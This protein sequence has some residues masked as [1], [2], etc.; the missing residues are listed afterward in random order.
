MSDYDKYVAEVEARRKLDQAARTQEFATGEKVARLPPSTSSSP[1]QQQAII[2]LGA[3]VERSLQRQMVE[4]FR[5]TSDRMASA[6]PP[7][8]PAPPA[9]KSWGDRAYNFVTGAEASE[10][11]EQIS[12]G[13]G[14]AYAVEQGKLYAPE[15]APGVNAMPRVAS[16]AKAREYDATDDRAKKYEIAAEYANATEALPTYE[17]FR[18]ANMP[19]WYET[20][21]GWGEFFGATIQRGAWVAAADAV[22]TLLPED[23]MRGD[24]AEAMFKSAF[25]VAR[26]SSQVSS[27]TGSIIGDMPF[28]F[29]A[30]GRLMDA[31]QS[32]ELQAEWSK[33][34]DH[35]F[36]DY[37][38]FEGEW[39]LPKADGI[40][41]INAA[42]PAD[43]MEEQARKAEKEG[44]VIRATA[45]REM[46][47]PFK[48]EMAGIALEFFLDPTH[49]MGGA[50][51]VTYVAGSDG[52]MYAIGRQ[53]SKAAAVAAEATGKSSAEMSRHFIDIAVGSPEQ[54]QKASSAL[55]EALDLVEE[56]AKQVSMRGTITQAMVTDP[57]AA[58]KA[59]TE[60]VSK[61]EVALDDLAKLAPGEVTAAKRYAAE[62]VLRDANAQLDLVA[63]QVKGGWAKRAVKQEAKELLQAKQKAEDL[64]GALN[65]VGPQV[66]KKGTF[67]VT[68]PGSGKVGYLLS[69]NLTSAAGARV[70]K[71][72]KRYSSDIVDHARNKQTA[73]ELLTRSDLIALELGEVSDQARYMK[74]F[75]F[76]IASELWADK[77][78]QP[79]LLKG[80]AAKAFAGTQFASTKV[81]ARVPADL[82]ENYTRSITKHIN[83]LNR[84]NAE[85]QGRIQRLADKAGEVVLERRGKAAAE[86]ANGQQALAKATTLAERDAAQA[87]IDR[88]KLWGSPDYS[89][90]HV[91]LEAGA[92]RERGSG[93]LEG[94][95]GTR[96]RGLMSAIDDVKAEIL[97]QYPTV[98][99]DELEQAAQA[100]M[101]H[102]VWDE[103]AEKQLANALGG[104]VGAYPKTGLLGADM[105]EYNK[106]VAIAKRFAPP[107]WFDD[108]LVVGRA[109][110]GQ[111]VLGESIARESLLKALNKLGVVFDG[112]QRYKAAGFTV[113]LVV[114]AMKEAGIT[115]SKAEVKRA[116]RAATMG[117]K[118]LKVD[119]LLK[120]LGLSNKAE[121]LAK[122]LQEITVNGKVDVVKLR[123]FK[124]AADL[125]WVDDRL[126][127]VEPRLVFPTGLG[128]DPRKL[129]DWE[130]ALWVGLQQKFQMKNLQKEELIMSAWASIRYAPDP[131]GGKERY[132]KLIEDYGQVIGK[133][134]D[135][136]P[137]D[138]IDVME[139]FR[140]LV[141]SYE[142]M[143]AKAGIRI[144]KDPL[145]RMVDWGVVDYVPHITPSTILSAK[146]GRAIDDE[147]IS[148]GIQGGEGLDNR[149]STGFDAAKRRRMLGTVEEINAMARRGDNAAISLTLN[150]E[151]MLARYMQSNRGI[152]AAELL[153]MLDAGG[154]MR[155]FGN[156][157]DAAAQGYVPLVSM[158]E[159]RRDIDFLNGSREDI[160]K[161]A[162]LEDL[163]AQRYARRASSQGGKS[164]PFA[165]W[166]F[167]APELK[168]QA[169]VDDAIV[170]ARIKALEDGKDFVARDFYK[171][172]YDDLIAKKMNPDDARKAAM[173]TTAGRINELVGDPD[174]YVQGSWLSPAAFDTPIEQMY[175]PATVV[176]SMQAIFGNGEP[177]PKIFKAYRWV[178]NFFKTRATII[179]MAFSARN[180]ASN[181]VSNIIDV[182]F[183]GALDP[184]TNWDAGKMATRILIA[185]AFGGG[186]WTEAVQNLQ[187]VQ[188]KGLGDKFN[189]S[190][191]K[192]AKLITDMG[193]TSAEELFDE[194]GHAVDIGD[195]IPRS[196]D[197]AIALYRNAGVIQ[198]RVGFEADM[199]V[200]YQG[201]LHGFATKSIRQKA[202]DAASMFEDAVLLVGPMSVGGVPVAL[203]KA[204]GQQVARM[205]EMQARLVNFTAN[206]KRGGSVEQAAM[207]VNKYLFDY[208]D[209][210]HLQKQYMRLIFPFWTW[211][212]KNIK[213]YADIA[214]ESPSKLAMMQRL[215]LDD[216]VRATNA[217]LTGEEQED[218]ITPEEMLGRQ[219]YAWSRVRIPT[220]KAG[221]WIE[222]LGLPIE[223]AADQIGIFGGLAKTVSTW[224]AQAW[225]DTGG[226]ERFGDRMLAQSSFMAKFGH[227][228]F[229]NDDPFRG[230]PAAEL[231]PKYLQGGMDMLTVE[232]D[233]AFLGPA[234]LAAQEFLH[235]QAGTFGFEHKGKYVLVN[236]STSA[237]K[238]NQ[239]MSQS[240]WSRF[241]SGSWAYSDM[242]LYTQSSLAD[243]SDR[244]GGEEEEWHWAWK[245]LDT[246]FGADRTNDVPEWKIRARDK[247]TGE[248]SDRALK[249]VGSV[250]RL[251]FGTL[252]TDKPR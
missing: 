6:P 251:E 76:D 2:D 125:N 155:R 108:D 86:L 23:T 243:P 182:G 49:G 248:E 40:D 229:L 236:P 62:R 36:V 97:K 21:P 161:Q 219:D 64:R 191:A 52:V 39:R 156:A 117:D 37:N 17:E 69:D 48:R 160:L 146:S 91:L 239:V 85:A 67:A 68:V 73:G 175:V 171:Q 183:G 233:L 60:T 179:M 56:Q 214:T 201:V 10:K 122:A 143:Y 24:V 57:Q 128:E 26:T 136:M 89:V 79:L 252:D 240:P 202:K 209:L 230:V 127:A 70:S 78:Y 205:T 238:L 210:T 16:M 50:R 249:M 193:Y 237:I 63:R 150:P 216:G 74:A 133:R 190:V 30:G 153:S 124:F 7:T 131:V 221:Q 188:G 247:E 213:L 185:D 208:D 99:A 102:G 83:Q 163:K 242:K 11:M 220:G 42:Y 104:L 75:T 59:A 46:N 111:K 176:A 162:N 132:D 217:A 138:L 139:E 167:A 168:K 33:K 94:S 206:V 32:G 3:R 38:P 53:T 71:V 145:Q 109:G 88:G 116:L 149:L 9:E 54:K 235:Q 241:Q 157:N 137:A 45:I 152:A 20:L 189:R 192:G 165:S 170:M 15:V 44:D 1:A 22:E 58:I 180:A 169:Q 148:K 126:R 101:R 147:L 110:L 227:A 8:V 173:N 90:D 119:D 12:K 204:W 218:L 144:T 245:V 174:L 13:R 34:M 234:G 200:A 212:T 164:S 100:I 130:A 172:T 203:P 61:A 107:G 222:G 211:T 82:W 66:G 184:R 194:L 41:V 250:K 95:M 224:E 31:V 228:L 19:A 47:T 223:S 112:S 120:E 51:G 151:H 5:A 178:E 197:E 93:L 118:K 114:D 141:L 106:A 84:I 231:S 28:H 135:D 177:L 187:R 72:V 43:L 121:R 92:A 207:H 18:A 225:Q 55:T 77:F 198:H 123:S 186:S 98:E 196:V 35:T 96:M 4:G 246:Y 129:K 105:A 199:A 158:T 87:M 226:F 27:P 134:L 195:G 29:D 25:A 159:I 154:I 80:K 103:V 65:V 142:D 14:A 81:L 113:D 244:S 232:R 215:L 166:R 181:V 115:V 140:A